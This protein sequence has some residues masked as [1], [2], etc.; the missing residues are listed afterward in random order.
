M[1]HLFLYEKHLQFCKVFDK[2]NSRIREKGASHLAEE[3]E[4]IYIYDD[5]SGGGYFKTTKHLAW[6]IT[7]EKEMESELL[8]RLNQ[9]SIPPIYLEEFSTLNDG[10]YRIFPHYKLN[11]NVYMF[12]AQIGINDEES[13]VKGVED[14]LDGVQ[15]FRLTTDDLGRLSW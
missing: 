3:I 15:H 10:V 6:L 4:N 12:R 2:I 7:S 9:R 8:D 13:Y 11:E 5:E 1:Y 14:A